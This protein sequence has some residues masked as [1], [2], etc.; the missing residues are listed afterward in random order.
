MLESVARAARGRLR[1]GRDRDD[2]RQALEASGRLDPDLIV[3]DITMPGLDGF[4]TARELKRMG[5]RA[6]IVFLTMHDGDEYI[7]EAIDCGAS[8]SVLKTR[9]HSDL[10]V[11]LDHAIAG[12]MFVPSVP[13]LA[14]SD[15]CGHAVHFYTRDEV[16][17]DVAARFLD[18]ALRHGD[19]IAVTL[20][21]A[22]RRAVGERLH[23]RAGI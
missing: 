16:F 1:C 17:V 19:V 15:Q 7:R 9:V 2:G 6:K 13:S 8:G 20:E 4:H 10:A 21:K 5:S 18:A 11:A 12:S 3:L 22:N 14:V 23:A